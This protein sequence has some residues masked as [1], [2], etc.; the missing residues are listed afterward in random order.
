MDVIN[1]DVEG[2]VPAF[3]VRIAEGGTCMLSVHCSATGEICSGLVVF[4]RIK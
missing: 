3:G 1:D 2:K 4:Q